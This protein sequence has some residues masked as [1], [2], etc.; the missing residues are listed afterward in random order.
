MTMMTASKSRGLPFRLCS[1]LT[2]ILTLTP[3]VPPSL[4]LSLTLSFS[5]HSHYLPRSGCVSTGFPQQTHKN[6]H[7]S[8]SPIISGA[9]RCRDKIECRFVGRLSLDRFCAH[10][11]CSIKDRHPPPPFP[12]PVVS[13]EVLACSRKSASG[14]AVPA[15]TA[16]PVCVIVHSMLL[17]GI[18]CRESKRQPER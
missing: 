7:S 12:R 17:R 15:Q 13:R 10:L 14:A 9:G 6:K 2:P 5:P 1:S 16:T 4:S 8:N 3:S 11:K 18:L